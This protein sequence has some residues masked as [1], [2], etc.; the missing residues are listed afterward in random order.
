LLAFDDWERMT[1]DFSLCNTDQEES[2]MKML[3]RGCR[4]HDVWSNLSHNTSDIS[5]TN[6]YA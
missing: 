3:A 4:V 2:N 6:A 1:H 5:P